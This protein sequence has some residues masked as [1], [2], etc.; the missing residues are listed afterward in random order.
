MLLHRLSLG[1]VLCILWLLLSGYF[2]SALLLG[3]GLA[4]AAAVVF[5]AH[6]MD[7]IDHEG[8][9]IHLGWRASTYLP[10][11]LGEIVKA[12]IDV[13][14]RIIQPTMPIGPNLLR[15]KGSQK[16]ELG[17]VIYANSITLT[18]GTVTVELEEGLLRVHALTTEAAE[19][20]MSGEMDRRVTTMEGHIETVPMKVE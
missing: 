20:V 11:L 18:P 13:A 12:N 8:H 2:S 3:L 7:V 19:E 1:L 10:W 4:S 14:W 15:V 6:R 16:S 17:N 9:P 5:I